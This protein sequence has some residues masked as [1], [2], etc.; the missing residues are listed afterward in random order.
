VKVEPPNQNYIDLIET[1]NDEAIFAN[2]V[3][4]NLSF[5]TEMGKET[6]LTRKHSIH[7]SRLLHLV[8]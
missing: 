2:E 8:S 1:S 3:N 4:E 6:N 7:S 5:I